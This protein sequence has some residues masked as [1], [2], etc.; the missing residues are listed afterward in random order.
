VSDRLVLHLVSPAS[1][2]LAELMARTVV[3]QLDGPVPERHLWTMVRSPAQLPPV[4]TAISERPGFVLHT[5]ADAHVREPLE[6]GCRV[7]NVPCMFVLEPFVSALAEHSGAQVRFRTSARDV[8]DEEYFRRLEAMRFTLAHDDGLGFGELAHA[9]VILVG[10]SRATKTPTCMYLAHRG[11]KAANVPLV[12]GVPAP[13]ILTKLTEPLIVGLTI[14]ATVLVKVR[15]ERMEMLKQ[16]GR[17]DYDNLRAVNKELADAKR[18]FER[19]GWPVINVS[20]RSIEQ[21]AAEIMDLL[22][23]RRM[24]AQA[25]PS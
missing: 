16:R 14:D 10:V 7:L 1:G 18:L 12:P 20:H 15:R 11:I 22:K 3:A 24:E 5:V 8:M 6:D 9:E 4:L 13:D 2:E 19:Q 23:R 21:S 17:S 25:A